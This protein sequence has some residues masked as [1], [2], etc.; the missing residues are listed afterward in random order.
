MAYYVL[1]CRYETAHSLTHVRVMV[2]GWVID[3]GLPVEITAQCRFSSY[4]NYCYYLLHIN[5]KDHKSFSS[6][7]TVMFQSPS[8]YIVSDELFPDR[9][10]PMSC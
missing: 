3:M 4:Y 10:M 6:K 5:D 7:L 2:K 8:S 1:M 9:S